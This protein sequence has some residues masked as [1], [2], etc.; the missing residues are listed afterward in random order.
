[1]NAF[2]SIKKI[3][4]KNL[5]RINFKPLLAESISDELLENSVEEETMI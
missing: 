4:K 2:S 3:A 1:M 5:D